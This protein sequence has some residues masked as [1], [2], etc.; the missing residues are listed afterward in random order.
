VRACGRRRRA[1]VVVREPAGSRNVTRRIRNR[2]RSRSRKKLACVLRA[3]CC[4]S[5]Q[6][7][8]SVVC[9]EISA[10]PGRAP[11]TAASSSTS[12][13]QQE[14]M[15][16]R[17]WACCSCTA[18]PGAESARPS[19]PLI[20]CGCSLLDLSIVLESVTSSG[21]SYYVVFC[22]CDSVHDM[23]VTPELSATQPSGEDTCLFRQPREVPATPATFPVPLHQ[24]NHAGRPAGQ[25]AQAR[26]RAPGRAL[27]SLSTVPG[28][29]SKVPPPPLPPGKGVLGV[30]EGYLQERN[31]R[32]P[33]A[34][35]SCGPFTRALPSDGSSST[36]T[37]I[38]TYIFTPLMGGW[39]G[40]GTGQGRANLTSARAAPPPPPPP[41]SLNTTGDGTRDTSAL[42][43]WGQAWMTLRARGYRDAGVRH[44]S[45]TPPP[46]MG[47][48]GSRYAVWEHAVIADALHSVYIQTYRSSFP[49][50]P[51]W[52]CVRALWLSS[53]SCRPAALHAGPRDAVGRGDMIADDSIAVSRSGPGQRRGRRVRVFAAASLSHD[54]C[55]C[56]IPS[57]S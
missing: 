13:K 39:A 7:G 53:R 36:H 4:S 41:V 28:R 9:I 52:A 22:C 49:C 5:P 21:V 54:S 3:A 51:A 46:P 8:S 32:S 47:L 12:S 48:G 38:H 33:P 56:C 17:A 26:A 6:A 31:P 37:Y 2:A 20:C 40:A 25:P 16:P 10:A 50:A 44:C 43:A 1:A 57:S 18:Q 11:P 55:V 14:T 23:T 42:G 24:Q 30:F 34:I 27:S 19:T 29:P 15:Q 45:V 35:R